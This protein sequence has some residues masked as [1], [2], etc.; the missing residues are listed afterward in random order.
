MH[1]TNQFL[2]ILA[3]TFQDQVSKTQKK[4]LIPLTSN[5]NYM[6]FISYTEDNIVTLC[7]PHFQEDVCNLPATM[8][9]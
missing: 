4:T 6:Y 2:E 7:I 3:L 9:Q 5:A 1:T 8:E